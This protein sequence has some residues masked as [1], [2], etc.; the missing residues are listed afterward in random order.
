M[1]NMVDLLALHTAMDEG[2]KQADFCDAQVICIRIGHAIALSHNVMR[3]ARPNWERCSCR[4]G[5]VSKR[6]L[7]DE[8]IASL[9]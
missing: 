3:R 8:N 4:S 7:C 5:V 2:C 1:V 6:E 9:G